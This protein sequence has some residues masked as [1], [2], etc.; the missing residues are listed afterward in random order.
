MKKHW[1]GGHQGW[2]GGE[3]AL[4]TQPDKEKGMQVQAEQ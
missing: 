1:H 3:K 2:A 4:A